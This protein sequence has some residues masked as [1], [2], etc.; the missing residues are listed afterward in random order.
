MN[1]IYCDICGTPFDPKH[2]GH[3]RDHPVMDWGLF[4]I[5]Q[6][7]HDVCPKCMERGKKVDFGE[8]LIRAWKEAA[9]VHL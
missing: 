9:D 3:R 6:T 8:A 2:G 1:M 4:G 5:A 7:N